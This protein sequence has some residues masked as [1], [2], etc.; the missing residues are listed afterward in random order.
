MSLFNNKKI[1]VLEEK[2]K[3]QERLIKQLKNSNDYLEM[4]CKST[5]YNLDKLHKE[6]EKLILWIEKITEG[7]GFYE[8]DEIPKRPIQLPVYKITNQF[9]DPTAN[10]TA[11]I[12]KVLIPEIVI[13]KVINK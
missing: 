9:D 3:G 7:L 6:N 4:S 11:R 10:G 1:E 2:I 12:E 13:S 5:F 8:L